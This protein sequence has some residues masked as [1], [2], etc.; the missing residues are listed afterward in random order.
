MALEYEEGASDPHTLP[1]WPRESCAPELTVQHYSCAEDCRT[2]ALEAPSCIRIMH[3]QLA[4]ESD[5]P[6]KSQQLRFLL[7]PT[8]SQALAFKPSGGQE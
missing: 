6:S 2:L 7:S 3:L 4:K 5:L 8:R 1:L